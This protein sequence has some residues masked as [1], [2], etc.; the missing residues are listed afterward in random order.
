[1]WRGRK[2]R[3]YWECRWR[4]ND[5]HVLGLASSIKCLTGN[6]QQSAVEVAL[7]LTCSAQLI[8]LLHRRVFSSEQ[9]GV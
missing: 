2:L 5:I 4:V 9:N 7:A 3:W 8:L 6:R 1:M